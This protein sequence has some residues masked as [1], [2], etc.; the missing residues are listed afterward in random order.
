MITARRL[1]LIS[2]CL[3][4]SGFVLPVPSHGATLSALAKDQGNGSRFTMQ[5]QGSTFDLNVGLLKV[6]PAE[7]R[8]IIEV[9]A[10]AQ[11]SDPLWQQFVIGMKGERPAV[12]AGYIQ[13]GD[14]APM[15]L[16]K[17][18]LVGIGGLDVSLFLVSEG[19]LRHGS[20]KDLKHLGQETIATPAGKVSCVHYRVEKP[21][22]QLDFWISDEAKPIGLVRMVSTGTQ[23]SDNYQLELQELLSGIAP[24]IN[25]AKAGPLSDEMKAVLTRP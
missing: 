2:T 19:D 25:P 20:T 16:P 7:G 6:D 3:I 17:Q 21:A 13:V 11:L 14:K 22:Q 23:P 12:E 18:H 4:L 5:S 8:V 15:V 1:V 10:A 9:F 24:K